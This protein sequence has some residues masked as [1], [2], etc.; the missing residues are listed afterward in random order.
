MTLDSN[1]KNDNSYHFLSLVEPRHFHLHY[2][3]EFS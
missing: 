1:N 3:I 2:H